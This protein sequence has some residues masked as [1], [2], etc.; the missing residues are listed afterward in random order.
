MHRTCCLLCIAALLA[1]CRTAPRAGIGERID[2]PRLSAHERAF[3]EALAHF[4]HGV[5]LESEQPRTP[6]EAIDAYERALAEDAAPLEESFLR[7]AELQFRAGRR[8]AAMQTITAARLRY[9]ASYEILMREAAYAQILEDHA[10][11]R[12]VCRRAISLD[13]AQP[14]AYAR[15][16][17]AELQI[18]DPDAARKTLREGITRVKEPGLLVDSL[19]LVAAVYRTRG[20]YDE[21]VAC[22]RT[23][24]RFRPKQYQAREEIVRSYVDAGRLED[25]RAALAELRDAEGL[26]EQYAMNLAL[27]HESAGL[28]EASIAYYREAI[29]ATPAAHPPYFRLAGVYLQLGEQTKALTLLE[30]LADEMPDNERLLLLLGD[31][32]ARSDHDERAVHYFQKAC[33][34]S[35]DPTPYLRLA[36]VRIEQEDFD[37]AAQV[38]RDGVKAFPT[39]VEPY[40]LLGWVESLREDYAAAAQAF[41]SV[42]Q[43]A[44]ELDIPLTELNPLYHFWAGSAYERLG[45]IEKAATYFRQCLAL[46]PENHQCMN[47]LAY[48]WAEH[49]VH[50]D[51]ALEFVRR[52]LKH[53]PENPAY[54]DTLGWIYF[55]QGEYGKALKELRRAQQLLPDDPVVTDHVGDALQALGRTD[56]ALAIWRLSLRLD[57]TNEAVAEKLRAAGV[58]VKA[59]R[60]DPVEP[61]VEPVP[62]PAE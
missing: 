57:P 58:D 52:A 28:L 25:A 34:V 60:A 62:A 33:D 15:K 53:E 8:E 10:R 41:D 26:P 13:P 17:Y 37:Q 1:G 18:E 19:P 36:I 9:P 38:L 11:V 6:A 61:A 35:T 16:A 32:H 50:L 49:G 54:I 14:V 44:T 47:Y 4:G 43:I 55:Q 20:R 5:L 40:T 31:I 7:V 3:A 45:E 22:Y 27:L 24:V 48:M 39:Q 2:D 12:E 51:E 21:A 23:I 56:E 46:Y 29:D 42:A 59:I 30:H